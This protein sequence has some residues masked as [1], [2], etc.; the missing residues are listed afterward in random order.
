MIERYLATADASP[1]T[2]RVIPCNYWRSLSARWRA[3]GLL[4][5]ASSVDQYE[6]R[7]VAPKYCLLQNVKKRGNLMRSTHTFQ[8]TRQDVHT[9]DS[10]TISKKTTHDNIGDS[11]ENVYYYHQKPRSY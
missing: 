5:G 3:V 4:S 1:K 6:Q 11:G 9:I 7:G 8:E 2:F 10:S